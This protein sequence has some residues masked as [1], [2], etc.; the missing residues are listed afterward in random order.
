MRITC[1]LEDYDFANLESDLDLILYGNRSTEDQGSVGAAIKYQI[2]RKKLIPAAKSWDLLTIALSVMSAD[3]AG[4]RAKS[5]DGWT[6]QFDLTISVI[7]APFWNQQSDLLKALFGFLTTD[8]WNFR[9]IEGGLYPQPDITM[10]EYPDEDCVVLLS[11]GL[12]SLIGTLD[13]IANGY[14]P[15]AVS[16][17]VRGD[18]KKQIQFA[19]LI[20]N[21]LNH[22]QANHNAEIPNQENPPSQRSRSIIFLAYGVLI[23][24]TLAKYHANEEVTLKICENGFIA[25]NPPLTGGRIGSLSTRTTHPIALGL[26]QQVLNSAGLRVKIENPYKFST[27]GEMLQ[28]CSDQTFLRQWA[29]KSTSCGRFKQFGYKHCGRCVPCL[30]RRAAFH[31]WGIPDQTNYVYRDL[32]INNEQHAKFDDVRSALVGI[33]A[34]QEL[35][36]KRWLGSCLSSSL[37]GNK[38]D[39]TATVERGLLELQSLLTSMNVR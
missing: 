2:S 26:L 31:K 17:T 11:G 30:I 10:A 21:G 9:F 7:D 15:Y 3:L 24:T 39:L 32:S 8:I 6:R 27:K 29:H 38:L 25:I 33:A 28:H 37:V 13:L 18:K 36:V 20:G 12:D 1:A 14:K 16:Q 4:H 35:G 5:P 22:F 23:A 19:Q 34:S